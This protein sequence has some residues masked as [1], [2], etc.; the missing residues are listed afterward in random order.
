MLIIKQVQGATVNLAGKNL[1]CQYNH[2]LNWVMRLH[3]I[4]QQVQKKYQQQGRYVRQYSSV[5]NN[6]LG[7]K[8]IRYRLGDKR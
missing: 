5:K 8:L 3:M 2:Q 6:S 4:H 1:I 7:D